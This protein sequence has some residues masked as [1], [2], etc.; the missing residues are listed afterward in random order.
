MTKIEFLAASLPYGLHVKTY[1]CQINNM[2]SELYT[3][4]EYFHEFEYPK[5]NEN[6]CYAIIRHL[7]TLTQK[8]IQA[9]YN[10]GKPFIPIVELA[11]MAFPMYSITLGEG[12]AWVDTD[13]DNLKF[14]FNDSDFNCEGRRIVNQLQLFQQL[15]RWHYWPNKPE[16]EE[17]VYV[18]ET[19]NPYK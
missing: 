10:E 6:I 2:K 15:I 12:F 16:N 4:L 9:D 13:W 8:C 7:Y 14:I 18:T 5:N 17:V 19:F 11:R 3:S 1:A